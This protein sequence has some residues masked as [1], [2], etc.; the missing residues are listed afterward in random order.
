MEDI[1]TFLSGLHT[2]F[3]EQNQPTNTYRDATNWIRLEDGS[4]TNE[5]GTLAVAG[6][7]VNLNV[8]GSI[9]ID[10][11]IIFISLADSNTV[12][13]KLD[14]D[15]NYTTVLTSSALGLTS[16]SRV[17]GVARKDYRG[18]T[19]IYFVDIVNRTPARVIDIDDV[20][21]YTDIGKQTKLFLD[22]DLPIV[23]ATEVTED[24]SLPTGVYQFTVRLLTA[25][26]NATTCSLLTNIVPIVDEFK[27]V[28]A[29]NYDG[30]LPQTVASKA[31][32]L[33]ITN[34]DTK[35]R[36]LQIICLTYEG[37]T[38]TPKVNVIGTV[39]ISGPTATFRYSSLTQND[40]ELTL[41]ELTVEPV[42]YNSPK[43]I[44]QKDSHLVL[45][46]LEATNY[47]PAF[48]AIANQ[49]VIKYK[50]KELQHAESMIVHTKGTTD[51]G[52][53]TFSPPSTEFN[54]YKGELNTTDY[55]GYQRGEIYSF[56]IAPI[57][58]NLTTGFA[59]HIPAP[60]A[61]TI[62]TPADANTT[63]KVLGT[64]KCGTA[65]YPAGF[66][67]PNE[68]GEGSTPVRYHKMP[69]FKQ[70]NIFEVSSGKIRVCGIDVTNIDLSSL[71]AEDRENI[72]GFAI[73]RELRTDDKKTILA[74]GIINLLQQ[75]T[76]DNLYVQSFAGKRTESKFGAFLSP[77]STIYR[78]DFSSA[79]QIEPMASLEGNSYLMNDER[80]DDNINNQYV[81]YFLKYD[82][83]D[84]YDIGDTTHNPQP[85]TVKGYVEPTTQGIVNVG[86]TYPIDTKGSNGF[87]YVE[88]TSN[89]NVYTVVASK[90]KVGADS[91]IDFLP[92]TPGTSFLNVL[93][94]GTS[95]DV[96]ATGTSGSG[97]GTIKRTLFNLLA[98]KPNSYG[99]VTDKEY[100]LIGYK[101]IPI[102][103]GVTNLECYGGDT[104][105]NKT[106]M[107]CYTVT[108]GTGGT[109]A[110]SRAISYYWSESTINIA[111][112][113]HVVGNT[114]G[115]FPKVKDMS[116]PLGG[117]LLTGAPESGHA[118]GYN[119]QY[120]FQNTLKKF[121][122]KPLISIDNVQHYPN[123]IIYSELSIE[124]EQLDAYRL[125]L[126]NNYHDIP[127][128]K[129]EITN[130]IDYKGTLYAHTSESF[131]KTSFNESVTQA[132]SAGEIVLGNGGI[133]NRPAIEIFPVS[134]GYAGSISPLATYT[135]P[136]GLFFVDG[137]QKKVFMYGESFEELDYGMRFKLIEFLKYANNAVGNKTNII[138]TYDYLY[139]R[140]ILTI[141]NVDNSEAHLPY[142]HTISYSPKLKS[143]SSYHSYIP[144][145]IVS[146]N[147][148]TVLT[149]LGYIGLL[150]QGEKG[151]YLNET[152]Q[153][154]SLT[155]IGNDNPLA[156]KTFDNLTI[157]SNIAFTQL[158]VSDS[159][160]TIAVELV[161]DESWEFEPAIDEQRITKKNS[162]YRVA[163]PINE[164]IDD[165][166]IKGKWA[167]IKLDYDNLINNKF[168]VKYINVKYRPNAR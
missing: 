101:L 25:S 63:T 161:E 20:G 153:P 1:K 138:S 44:T 159:N 67:Y 3:D 82:V 66:G 26:T 113:H 103:S 124:G 78:N 146:M 97:I 71:P 145:H 155:I 54:N 108:P 126:T 140:W 5:S 166:R 73:T 40:E 34:I 70:E 62:G 22:S 42:T 79:I 19:L 156:G 59:Y 104:F 107:M 92:N 13:G 129:G 135:S 14:K 98:S 29:E 100:V 37:L 81:H 77:E 28:G 36:Y 122:S 152:V 16:T 139:D 125:F 127:K 53:I 158:E 57:F 150:N 35:Y 38:N 74:Q 61:G 144:T 121:F 60:D 130:V 47:N 6:I 30:A 9:T 48:Q 106:S 88:A 12:I 41:D 111:Y 160:K 102:D 94:N 147:Q 112:R 95:K 52:T 80:T 157:D 99:G 85:I 119:K 75:N 39:A 7:P 24:G 51:A 91:E 32:N 46:N 83:C 8:I 23:K 110:Q 10:E 132:T 136:H 151:V 163:I 114:V 109:L 21:S 43:A 17:K 137:L 131:W 68:S 31:I 164:N 141:N 18:N 118:N 76:L 90:D 162:E 33:S 72:I 116:I 87:F 128:N 93:D 86:G 105:I 45:A 168:I 27:S 56:A 55:T 149:K 50:I 11:D 15:N 167:S 58:K 4:L 64:F 148:R 96:M 165:S 65:T 84:S 2:N 134:G 154:S 123:R 143:W 89:L 120:S 117:G 133:F 69:T 49:I 115:Y 142:S